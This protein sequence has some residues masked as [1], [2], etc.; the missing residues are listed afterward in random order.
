[1]NTSRGFTSL[2]LVLLLVLVL[3][4]A[5]WYAFMRNGTQ[6]TEGDDTTAPQIEDRM[7]S[8]YTNTAFGFSI[9]YDPNSMMLGDDTKYQPAESG[10]QSI[11]VT[12][13]TADDSVRGDVLVAASSRSDDVQKCLT[14]PPPDEGMYRG[15][16]TST[17]N[18]VPFLTYT[19]EYKGEIMGSVESGGGVQYKTLRAGVCY[20]IRN[21][22]KS[23][24][25]KPMAKP[26]QP[27]K[28]QMQA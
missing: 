10:M 20:V 2:G 6:Q 19:Y 14:I 13:T 1:M 17:I 23:P 3:G 28:S 18:G 15:T 16:G 27:S 7:S 21:A 25:P 24:A 4:G 22:W 12:F 5:G 9:Q 26:S 8:T 11:G